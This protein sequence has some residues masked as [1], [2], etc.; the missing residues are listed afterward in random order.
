MISVAAGATFEA[1]AEN[2]PTGLVGV[3]GVAI[4]DGQGDVVTARTTAG[5]VESPDDSGI[6]TATLTAPETMGQYLIVWDDGS[7]TYATEDLF[8]N[9]AGNA[10]AL[11]DV[12]DVALLLR[13]RTYVDGQ[14][15]G[16]FTADTRPTASDVSAYISA[17]Y[18]YLA[19]RLGGTIPT[20][21]AATAKHLIAVYA[22][23]LIE[24][25]Y[26]PEQT[27]DDSSV[28]G[29]LSALFDAQIVSLIDA[30][31]DVA[32]GPEHRVGSVPI[33]SP[34]AAAYYSVYGV[35][36]PTTFTE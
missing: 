10:D 32:M 2:A 5:I 13:A 36:L 30:L 16:T 27:G 11:P 20:A 23:M 29:R 26:S 34:T 17:A 18:S 31:A 7:S 25:S 12:D 24:Q 22:A 3:I 35:E 1:T 14:Y 8:V 9:L 6:Y 28:F 15:I 21:Q 33:G 19:A 4:E